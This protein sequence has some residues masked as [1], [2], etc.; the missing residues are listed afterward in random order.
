MSWI[1]WRRKRL[2]VKV[3]KFC[4]FQIYVFRWAA[5]NTDAW[6]W[7]WEDIFLSVVFACPQTPELKK[8]LRFWIV[9]DAKCRLNGYCLIVRETFLAP[10]VT[11]FL[12]RPVFV[13]SQNDIV[14]IIALYMSPTN[15][16]GNAS[17]DSII[18]ND[19]AKILSGWSVLNLNKEFWALRMRKFLQ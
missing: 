4:F 15:G 19:W 5:K 17:P 16:Q 14:W 6:Q 11:W 12:E 13:L 18:E 10:S 2:I 1:P 7:W 8:W 9:P 3:S